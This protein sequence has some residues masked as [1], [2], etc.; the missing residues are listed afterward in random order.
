VA[1]R[2]PAGLG[3]QQPLRLDPLPPVRPHRPLHGFASAMS[4]LT[5]AVIPALPAGHGGRLAGEPGGRCRLPPVPSH[6]SPA[7]LRRP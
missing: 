4:P 1:G 7:M 5:A 3:A 6:P 2:L